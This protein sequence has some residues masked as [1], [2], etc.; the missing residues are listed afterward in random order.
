MQ[1]PSGPVAVVF[2]D[3]VTGD[4]FCRSKKVSFLSAF[5]AVCSKNAVSLKVDVENSNVLRVHAVSMHDYDWIV[6]V[7][8]RLCTSGHWSVKSTG[9][10]PPSESKMDYVISQHLL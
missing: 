6:P 3:H 9:E 4:I 10:I 2:H 1:E 8:D 5:N 7:V